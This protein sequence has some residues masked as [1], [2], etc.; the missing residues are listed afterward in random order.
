M[1]APFLKHGSL[2]QRSQP[3]GKA[4][5]EV[6]YTTHSF[7]RHPS[8][9]H[10][11]IRHPHTFASSH[12]C[13]LTRHSS[14]P[15]F[16][17]SAPPILTSSQGPLPPSHPHQGPLSLS[18]PHQAGTLTTYPLILTRNPSH[19]HHVMKQ[20]TLTTSLTSSP[21]TPS[22][23]ITKIGFIHLCWLRVHTSSSCS[24]ELRLR[25]P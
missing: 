16:L 2:S 10:F 12:F 3:E 13:I 11:L 7:T 22:P 1:C 15:H 5:C 23:G 17:T 9:H 24:Q 14:Y 20:C 19:S 6:L 8:H 18:H 25:S 4:C 21:L